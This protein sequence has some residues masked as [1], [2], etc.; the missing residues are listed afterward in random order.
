MGRQT[1]EENSRAGSKGVRAQGWAPAGR[2]AQWR[3]VTSRQTPE[4]TE[5]KLSGD[6]G[7]VQ[8]LG[9]LRESLR[10]LK[11]VLEAEIP[12][13]GRDWIINFHL[14]SELVALRFFSGKTPHISA[15]AKCSFFFF[16][17]FWLKCLLICFGELSLR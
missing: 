16:S 1:W 14:H 8:C 15:L 4:I 12:W 7:A 13:T 10:L 17:F 11:L 3:G 6:R 9:Q 5:R 2:P